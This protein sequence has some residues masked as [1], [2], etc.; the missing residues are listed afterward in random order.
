MF[1]NMFIADILASC[2]AGN[3]KSEQTLQARYLLFERVSEAPVRII[4]GILAA[5]SSKKPRGNPKATLESLG[6]RV[7]FEEFSLLRRSFQCF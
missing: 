3:P 7:V 2:L 6:G 4:W 1:R 5:A